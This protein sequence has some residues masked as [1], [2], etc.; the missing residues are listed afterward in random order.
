MDVGVIACTGVARWID[1]AEG[2][3]GIG[4]GI[5]IADAVYEHP[6]VGANGQDIDGSGEFSLAIAVHHGNVTPHSERY[7]D[8]AV[9]IEIGHGESLNVVRQRDALRRSEGAIA[10][11]QIDQQI[12]F[13]NQ[14]DVGFAIVVYVGGGEI[15]RRL[16]PNR[17]GIPD[18]R[19]KGAVAGR[20]LHR[21][22]VVGG[23]S[24]IRLDQIGNAVSVEVG[25]NHPAGV[26]DGCSLFAIEGGD[27]RSGRDRG[28]GY[29]DSA[30]RTTETVHET[31][32]CRV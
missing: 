9:M 32:L 12:L 8:L 25:G 20:D 31:S 15:H 13:I 11:S 2:D 22:G 3:V 14:D 30:E 29:Q 16:L 26:L 6:S 19:S 1:D 18:G 17:K 7:I 4:V 23:D 5:E 21:K 24:R 27:P 28:D 10:V